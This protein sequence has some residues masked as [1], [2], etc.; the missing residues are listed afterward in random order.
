[1]TLI[2]HILTQEAGIIDTTTNK[3]GDQKLVSASAVPCHFRYI[4]GIEKN[5]NAEGMNSEAMIWFE[6]DLD[7]AEA[8]LVQIEGKYWRIDRLIKARR[9]SEDIIFLKAFV[10]RHEL[11]T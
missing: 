6:P 8:S 11:S 5:I 4:T 7:I 10:T 1:M 2:T 9:F 3:Y